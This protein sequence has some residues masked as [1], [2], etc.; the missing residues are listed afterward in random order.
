MSSWTPPT[1]EQL[2]QIE[3]LAI[4]P[5]N[6]AYFFDRLDNPEWVS[7]LADRGFFDGPPDPVPADK[8]GYVRFPPWPEGRYL[9]R[10][11]SAAPDAVASVLDGLSQSPNPT[12]TGILLEAAQGL[13]GEHL[14]PLAPRIVQWIAGSFADHFADE[15][16]SLVARL[17]DAGEVSH[18]LKVARELLKLESRSGA[19]DASSDESTPVLR[20]RPGSELS[21][22]Q[23]ERVLAAIV[24]NLVD[25]AGLEALKLVSSLLDDA[26]R[27]SRLEGEGPDSDGHSFIW[28]PAIEDHVQNSER[29]VRSLLVSAVRDAAVRLAHRGETEL[30]AT[31]RSLEAGT[32]LHQR[33][34]LHV[35]ATS[36]G[37]AQLANDRLVDRRLFD[38]HRVKHE[39]VALL[40]R[41]FGDAGEAVQR[42]FLDWVLAGP[43]LEEFR[44]RR[45]SLDGA[46]PDADEEAAYIGVWQRDWLGFVAGHLD[47]EA[48]ALHQELLERFGE[49][50]HPDFLTWSSSWTGPESP[51]TPDEV[52]QWSPIE[53]I[54][55][56]AGWHPDDDS[57]LHFGPS[58]EGLGRV[59][60]EVVSGRAVEFANVADQA[61]ALDP[62]YVRGFLSGLE[63]AV[64]DGASIS[65]GPPLQLLGSVVAHPFEPD[66]EAADRDRDP[67]WRWARREAASLIRTG[68]ADRE[69]QIPFEM[70]GLVW[71]ILDRLADDPNPSPGHEATYG[72]DMDPF[73]L[74][75]NTNRGTAMHAV[76]EYSLWCRRQHDAQGVDVGPG[77]DLFPEA[78]EVLQDHLLPDREPSLAVRSVY[79][80]WLPWLLLLDERW[81]L[82]NITSILPTSP[83]LAAFRDAAWDTYIGWCQP[84]DS[85]FAA[86]RGEYT[87]AVERVPSSGTVGLSHD[88]RAD[89]KLGEHLITFY[90]RGVA[91]MSLLDRWFARSDD[92]LAGQVMG[93]IGRALRN[94]DG[95]VPPSVQVRI[96]EA[97]DIRL[98]VIGS[99]PQAHPREAQAFASAFVSD[100]LDHN[101][102]L[103]S[104][105]IAVDSAGATWHGGQVIARLTEVA[106]A[107]SATATRLTL[108]MLHGT[109]NDWDHVGWRDEVRALLIATSDSDDEE[110]VEN[111]SAI[112]DFYVSRGEHGLRGLV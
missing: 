10:V 33:I 106:A 32:L 7:A 102:A 69:N 53:A 66:E 97:W 23:Y 24:P 81:V 46:S 83:E 73:T 18:A 36:P 67:G 79:G 101:W 14:R 109:A 70:R 16:A 98:E 30:D 22:W 108:K 71:E 57:G 20:L 40:R 86:L 6:R 48:A 96:Q 49:P 54:E 58:M 15:A 19:G 13:S 27:Y 44:E 55:Y 111:R 89:V 31:V 64:K 42:I 3:V 2:A 1:D 37:G 78:R 75:I 72:G 87:E 52:N 12:V 60:K 94:T 93:F 26:L 56:L 21:D 112:V 104:L 28:R 92:D 100:K 90:W 17:V 84:Y 82:A 25:G 62:T 29:D 95:E 63:T 4:R 107:R 45:T 43:D 41:R 47:D 99:D 85:V 61:A 38:D 103:T 34:A 5:E 50:D 39:Y 88:E 80:R 110:T 105:E 51:V 68:V 76:V 74:S 9:A 35:L 77:F 65:W 8:P 91:P 59:V 11:A